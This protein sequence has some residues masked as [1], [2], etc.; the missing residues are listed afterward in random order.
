MSG[1]HVCKDARSHG[2]CVPLRLP[3]WNSS[4]PTV[5]QALRLLLAQRLL[6]PCAYQALGQTKR[7]V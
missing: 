6:L 2:V 4:F 5:W 7:V 1:S 3:S